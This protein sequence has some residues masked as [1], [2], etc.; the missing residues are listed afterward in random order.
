MG[1]RTYYILGVISLVAT[2][3]LSALGAFNESMGA[4]LGAI[5]W[6]FISGCCFIA[7]AKHDRNSQ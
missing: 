6:G 5:A 4:G 7:S 3:V 2:F 1:A